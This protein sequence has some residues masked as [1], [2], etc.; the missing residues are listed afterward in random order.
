MTLLNFL[1]VKFLSGSPSSWIH[2]RI[3]LCYGRGSRLTWVVQRS[4]GLLLNHQEEAAVYLEM[5]SASLLVVL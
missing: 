2:G 5:P 3:Y 4:W 1:P